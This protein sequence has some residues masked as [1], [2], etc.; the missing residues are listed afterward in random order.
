M[1]KYL[2][3][4]EGSFQK[5]NMHCHSTVSDG[6]KTAEE[7]KEAYLSRG[8]SILAFTDHDRFVR[9]NDLSDGSFL[10][11]NAYEIGFAHNKEPY[12]GQVVH[13]NLYAKTPDITEGIG[14]YDGYLSPE[15]V[16]AAIQTAN[17]KGFFVSYNHPDWS[18]QT[19]LDYA[20]YEGYTAFEVYNYGCDYFSASGYDEW[21]LQGY[22]AL[23]NRGRRLLPFAT[24]D[25]Q[26]SRGI[27]GEHLC[28]SFGGFIGVKT[29]D[30]RYETV[31]KAILD[32]QVYASM[33]PEF[34]EAYIEDGVLFA[35]F[36][37]VR[38]LK[39]MSSSRNGV[40]VCKKEGELFTE[41][42]VP[43]KDYHKNIQLLLTDAEGKKAVTRAY[44]AEEI[45][46]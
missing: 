19:L 13:L 25:N 43:L 17:E 22:R 21:N 15:N 41:A 45:Y 8:Y 30:L 31:V 6:R 28:D 1:K 24:D 34:Y 44:F 32:G 26:N 33:G 2:F 7:L 36:S 9:H 37:P 16:N 39:L 27:Q 5:A 4:P 10:A 11:L 46:G 42:S 18:L 12:H 14:E 3:S 23:V 38:S 35:R 40:L 20:Q 29:R